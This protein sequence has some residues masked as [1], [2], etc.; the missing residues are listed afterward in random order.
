MSLN[1]SDQERDTNNLSTEKPL[2]RSELG[3]SSDSRASPS[4]EQET[5]KENEG[6]NGNQSTSQKDEEQQSSQP[7]PYVLPSVAGEAAARSYLSC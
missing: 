1:R 4:E 5:S 2:E 7:E 6:A 3:S